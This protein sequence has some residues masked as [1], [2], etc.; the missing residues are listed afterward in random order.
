MKIQENQL[1]SE[2]KFDYVE[3]FVITNDIFKSKE[4]QKIVTLSKELLLHDAEVVTRKQQIETTDLKLDIRDSK[5]AFIDFDQ[6]QYD[7]MYEKILPAFA[8]ANEKYFK[9]DIFGFQESFQFAEYNAPCGH[10]DDHTDKLLKGNVRKLTLV[11]QLSD[12]RDYEGG[13]LQLMLGG[14]PFTVPK[15]QGSM[16]IFPSYILHRVTPTTK[17]TRHTLVGWSTGA[18]FR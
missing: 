11:I 12:P 10:Y 13:E 15:K 4:C 3:N 1:P 2:C 6:S 5:I 9:F 7:W 17:G 8:S 14:E 18:P 16:I